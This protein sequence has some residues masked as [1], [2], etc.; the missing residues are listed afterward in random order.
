MMLLH[1]CTLNNPMEM[2]YSY[3]TVDYGKINFIMAA[4]LSKSYSHQLLM[5]IGQMLNENPFYRITPQAIR[6]I[7]GPFMR[8]EFEINMS[9]NRD[10]KKSIRSKHFI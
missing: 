1:V 3:F 7:Y 6:D 2:F 10:M 4:Q 8:G 9:A 5:L